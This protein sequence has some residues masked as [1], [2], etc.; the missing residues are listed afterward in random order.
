[1]DVGGNFRV[2]LP[3]QGHF[4]KGVLLETGNKAESK[5]KKKVI[6]DKLLHVDPNSVESSL[7]RKICWENLQFQ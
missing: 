1:M 7:I 6:S 4:A 5:K 2:H 3:H